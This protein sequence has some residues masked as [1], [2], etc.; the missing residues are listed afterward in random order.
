MQY[1]E[2]AL[3]SHQDIINHFQKSSALIGWRKTPRYNPNNTSSPLTCWYRI[4]YQWPL[5]TES[6]SRSPDVKNRLTSQVQS[7]TDK[8]RRTHLTR[9]GNRRS[10]IWRFIGRLPTRA[11][12]YWNV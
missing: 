3:K 4:S 1:L 11:P 6:T 5:T 2:S 9:Y 7:L 10:L 8:L 12:K